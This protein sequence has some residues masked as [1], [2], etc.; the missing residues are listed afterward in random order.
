MVQAMK[1]VAMLNTEL[2]VEER[3]LLSV[4]YKNVIYSRR[5]AWR[6]VSS[7]EQKVDSKTSKWQLVRS[8]RTEIEGELEAICVDLLQ[9]L[10]T[11]LLPAT[12]SQEAKVL[13]HKMYATC[14]HAPPVNPS[15]VP[16]LSLLGTRLHEP[17]Q[18][19]VSLQ[20]R[21]LLSIHG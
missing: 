13:Y 4:G 20:E 15:L 12:T 3:N 10:E 1:H 17:T 7:I 6:S 14:C 21:G 19:T 5:A 11:H 8:Y 18:T 2:T 16:S 9:L